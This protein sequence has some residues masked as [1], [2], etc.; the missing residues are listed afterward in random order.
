MRVLLLLSVLLVSRT[1][2]QPI[3]SIHV[4]A[5]LPQGSWTSASAHALAWQLHRDRAPHRTVK[6]G[7]IAIV[8]EAMRLYRPARHT[9]GRLPDLSHVAMLFSGGRP[10]VLGV[11]KELGRVIDLT[12][13]KE[14]TIDSLADHAQVRLLLARA[15]VD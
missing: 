14:Y 5:R 10:V 3:D 9:Y 6:E 8:Q 11:D 2:A 12:S 4:F 1:L 13:R 7:D 15:M